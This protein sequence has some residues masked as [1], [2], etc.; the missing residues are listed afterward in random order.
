MLIIFNESNA[1]IIVLEFSSRYKN[2]NIINFF[3]IFEVMFDL[4][5][6]L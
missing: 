1:K 5:F 6:I 2:M 4:V 3:E